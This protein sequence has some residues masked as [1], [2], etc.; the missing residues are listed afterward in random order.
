MTLRSGESRG[1]KCLRQFPGESVADHEAAKTDQVQI[2]VLDP[3]MRRKVFVN[4]AGPNPRH[5]VRADRCPDTAATNAHAAIHRSGGNRPCQRHDKIGIVVRLSRATV[6]K[7]N[8]FIP[9][10]AQFPGQ[11]FLQL[12]TAVVGG[13][14]DAFWQKRQRPIAGQFTDDARLSPG[15]CG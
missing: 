6:A 12:I 14:A 2:V 7:V 5:F 15:W 8:R 9:G 3:L 1:K 4:Q 11:I 13:D 10:C